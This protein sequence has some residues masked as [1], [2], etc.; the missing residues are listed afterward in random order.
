MTLPRAVAALALFCLAVPHSAEPMPKVSAG[1]LVDLGVVQSRYADPRR[2]MVWLPNGYR[3]RG[4]K[5]AVLYMH[6]GQNLF[7]A[8]TSLGGRYFRQYH[9]L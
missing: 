1:T 5:Y 6:D 7:D 2:V 4:A 3:P 9:S 8:A